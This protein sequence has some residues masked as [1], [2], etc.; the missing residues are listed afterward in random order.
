MTPAQVLREFLDG[1]DTST[2]RDGVVTREEFTEYYRGVSANIP[3]ED[4]FELMMRNAW[5]ISGGSVR[6]RPC[7]VWCGVLS[8]LCVLLWMLACPNWCAC[9]CC[10][11]V[12]MGVCAGVP[13]GRG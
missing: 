5:H 13:A 3:R 2:S 10:F 12:L 6:G 11:V 1:F 4:Y 7:L 8:L 9:R